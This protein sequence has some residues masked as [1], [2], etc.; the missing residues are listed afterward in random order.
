MALPI[1]LLYKQAAMS[2]SGSN[3][4]WNNIGKVRNQGL[5]LEVALS[6]RA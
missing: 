6:E 1:R 4:Y 2:F 5:E 3:Q